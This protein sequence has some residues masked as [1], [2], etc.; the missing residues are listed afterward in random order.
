M[1]L[2]RILYINS[3]PPLVLLTA[4][5]PRLPTGDFF[6]NFFEKFL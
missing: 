2:Y 6:Q 3:I 4:E 5:D 1:N